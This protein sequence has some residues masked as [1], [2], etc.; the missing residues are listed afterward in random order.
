MKLAFRK[1]ICDNSNTVKYRRPDCL[2][3][4]ICNE[5]LLDLNSTMFGVSGVV[6][7]LKSSKGS[8]TQYDVGNVA[9]ELKTFGK[10]G[11][12]FTTR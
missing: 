9:D 6:E 7:E 8:L 4:Y 5:F 2:L 12:F 1:K 3:D 11:K 10:E